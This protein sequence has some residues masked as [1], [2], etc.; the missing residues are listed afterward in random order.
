MVYIHP[1]PTY[2]HIEQYRERLQ[3]LKEFGGSDNELNIRAA[4]QNCLASYCRSHRENLELVPEL[5]AAGGV[6]PDGTVKDSI[7]LSRGY[8]EA[9]DL[10]DNLDAEIQNKLNRGYPDEN[11]LFENSRTAVLI[12][13]GTVARRADM[14]DPGQLHRLVQSFLNFVTREV[15]EF[16]QAWQQFKKDLPDILEALRGAIRRAAER[17]DYQTAAAGFL[18]LC[19]RTI[20]PDVS[21]EH[22]QEM[23]IQHILT[24]D[25][26]LRVFSEDQYHQENNIARQLDALAQTFFTGTLRRDTTDD[27]LPYYGAITGAAANIADYREKQ[28]FLKAIYEDFYQTYNP[29]AADRLG[30]VYTPNEVVDFIIRGADYLLQMHFGR[31]LADDNVQILDPATGTGT[32][33]TSLIDYLPTD[34]LEY[35]Y[36][37][38]IH[39]NEV[40]ILPYYIANLNI[41]Y[42]YKE[43]NG[44]VPGIL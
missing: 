1:M 24:K 15:E 19:H 12:Q 25:I 43:K 14:R 9:K 32:F 10:H 27:L 28:R 29:D 40:A 31:S 21:E 30:V 4:F 22:V 42:S 18:E 36:L 17:G 23:L 35:K 3:Q 7:R 20:G 26:F 39:A 33:I 37:N 38:E 44:A 34:K 2:P 6:I 11:I 8:W 16:R 41:E 5:R 13:R